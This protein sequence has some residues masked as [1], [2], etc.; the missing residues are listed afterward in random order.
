LGYFLIFNNYNDRNPYVVC[1]ENICCDYRVYHSS[2]SGPENINISIVNNSII[3]DQK[4]NCYCLPPITDPE[5][6]KIELSFIGNNLT[7]REIFTPKEQSVTLCFTTFRINGTI[8]NIPKGNYNLVYVF[9]NRHVDQV[10]I[11]KVFEICN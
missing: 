1:Y 4:L 5:Y 11:K 3:F 10:H 2:E 9:E 8:F 6:F 7:L